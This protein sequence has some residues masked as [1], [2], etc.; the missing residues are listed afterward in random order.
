MTWPF[1]IHQPHLTP[2]SLVHC[3]SDAFFQQLRYTSP[4]F[5][6]WAKA[7]WRY[8]SWTATCSLDKK[9]QT[10]LSLFLPARYYKPWTQCKATKGELWKVVRR[11]QTCLESQDY[12]TAPINFIKLIKEEGKEC[13]RKSGTLNRRTSWSHS[14]GT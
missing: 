3:F 1:L 7:T 5:R 14:R 4:S 8:Q 11:R 6:S 9:A 13:C 12:E 2:Y 10:L